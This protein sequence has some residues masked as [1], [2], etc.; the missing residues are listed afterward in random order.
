MSFKDGWAAL[1]LEMPPRV[2]RTEY[3]AESH[4]Q[5]IKSVT[6]IE[7]D[8]KSAEEQEIEARK[9]FYKAWNYDLYWMIW[10]HTVH[11]IYAEKNTS[12]GHA[13]YSESG[14]DFDAK[15]NCPFSSPEQVLDFDPW[16]EYSKPSQKELSK[17][18]EK[19]YTNECKN[20]PDGVSMTGIYASLVSGLIEIFGWD[21]MLLA[22]GTDP[23]RFGEMTNR[24]ALWVKQYF[25]ALAAADVPVVMI[26]DDICWTSGPF[27]SPDWYR[28]Y[29]FPNHK[30]LFEPLI[31]SGKKVLY[32]SDGNYT[33]FI[34]DIARCGVH[35]FVCE[36]VTDM[37]YIAEKYGRTHVFVGNADTKVL[38]HGT[39][40]EIENEVKRCMDIGKNCPG[41]FIAV[42]NHIPPNTP[43][44][45]A[46]FYNELVN[47]LGIR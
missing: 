34:D 6:G 20:N 16:Q 19:H 22:L 43:V 5:L 45:N 38:L 4:W 26:H 28:Q 44:E 27:C 29:V 11:D 31:D 8:D 15:I 36:P 3:S 47:R 2:P 10:P 46:V 18:F 12:M 41:Y 1:N 17:E 37:S 40:E 25:D 7:V 21:M 9:A 24:L 39:R 23:V 35:G 33:M 13:S 42:G 14:G 32:T 30:M